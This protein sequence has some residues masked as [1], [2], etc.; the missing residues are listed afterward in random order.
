M[1]KPKKQAERMHGR[2]CV[3]CAFLTLPRTRPAWLLASC[4]KCGRVLSTTHLGD[5][6][7]ARFVEAW[8]GKPR[9]VTAAWSKHHTKRPRRGAGVR[10]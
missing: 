2:G 6:D 3:A 5:E 1:N 10:R 4:T 8:L 9:D 7:H